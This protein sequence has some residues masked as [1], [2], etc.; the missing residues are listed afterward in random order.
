M[1]IKEA[2]P[3][4]VADVGVELFN[5]DHHR[6]LFYIV[7]FERLAERFLQREPFQDEWDQLDSIF[8]RLEKYTESHF[9]AEEELMYKYGY[10][11]L[12]EHK[13]QHNRL[14]EQ[15]CRLQ[16]QIRSREYQH[17]VKLRSF[18]L[19]WLQTHISQDDRK[20]R[21]FFQLAESQNILD[22][23]LF[24][25]MI[26]TDQ[27]KKIV[28]SP[29]TGAVIVDLRS[30]ME[31]QEGIIP[32][33]HLYPCDHNLKNRQDTTIFSDF[34]NHI[35]DPAHFDPEKYY[36]LICRSGPRTAIALEIFIDNG[37]KA[38]ELVGGIEEWK[39]QQYPLVPVDASTLQI[40]TLGVTVH[41]P[42]RGE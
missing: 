18:L 2:A 6:L 1:D 34:F 40:S 35:F 37:L 30:E 7:E 29:P 22:K 42:R 3:L 32:S 15:V 28:D 9:K 19:D 24:N 33:S 11:H 38:C 16:S 10:P 13:G 25:E 20:Y 5:N 27:L 23:A 39:R 26:S 4:T 21:G 8:P 36:I 14:L 12:E 41:S 31:Q 17:I